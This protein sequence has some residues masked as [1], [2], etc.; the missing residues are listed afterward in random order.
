MW[1]RSNYNDSVLPWN[2]SLYNINKNMI[3]LMIGIPYGE[4]EYNKFIRIHRDPRY[5]CYLAVVSQIS[6]PQSFV[7]R[8]ELLHSDFRLQNRSGPE[9]ESRVVGNRSNSGCQSWKKCQKVLIF[10]TKFSSTFIT[11]T[12]Y[13]FSLIQ[14]NYICNCNI[15]WRQM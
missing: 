11:T 6:S 14:N 12:K 3:I 7:D 10:G 9:N 5:K 8:N 13:I 4:K 2:R 1:P 15:S